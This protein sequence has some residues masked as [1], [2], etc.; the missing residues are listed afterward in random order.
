MPGSREKKPPES[1]GGNRAVS[2][3]AAKSLIERDV[4]R[5]GQE[6]WSAF[7]FDT[8]KSREIKCL[9]EWADRER[10][11]ID[12]PEIGVWEGGPGMGEH[13]LKESDGR[14]W[15]ATKD[16]RFGIWFHAT[17][18]VM[19]DPI[20]QIKKLSSA[21]PHQY[22]TRLALAN[23]WTRSLPGLGHETELTRLEGVAWLDD[24]FCIITSQPIFTHD[25]DQPSRG[26][27]NDWFKSQGFRLVTEGIFYRPDDDLG[28]FDI[29]P[30]NIIRSGGVLVP[31]DVI[32][33]RP[34]GLLASVI[35]K[36]LTIP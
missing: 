32:P 8:A 4:G 30:S 11:W 34:R 14:F 33:I 10:V 3:A 35:R 29:K 28:L 24:Q 1:A 6:C 13:H 2:I 16:G 25:V 31:V 26:E 21:T 15:K 36:I 17:G 27:L 22:L 20:R 19:G 23:E 9:C 5:S 7:D 18:R 12:S